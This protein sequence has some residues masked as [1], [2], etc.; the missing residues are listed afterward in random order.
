MNLM[1][2]SRFLF[3]P[4]GGVGHIGMN[5]SLYHYDGKWI[6]VDLG[7]GF[8]NDLMPGVDITV[9]DVSFIAERKN[10]LL[11]IVLTHAH[12]DHIGAI[13]YLWNELGCPLFATNFTANF[14]KAK[15]SEFGLLDKVTINYVNTGDVL[16]IG[17]FKIEFVGMTHSIPEAQSLVIKTVAG[18]VVHTGDWKI[19]SD[20]VIGDVSNLARLKAVGDEGVDCLVCDSTNVFSLGYSGTEASV[21][22]GLLEV[23]KGA[24]TGMVAVALFASNI[25][26]IQT[27]CDVAKECGRRICLLGRSLW[28]IVEVAKNSGYLLDVEE[29]VD[30]HETKLIDREK[31]LLICTGC[32]G[33]PDAAAHKLANLTHPSVELKNGDTVVFSS[34]IIPGNECRIYQMLNLFAQR[35]IHVITSTEKHVHV[36]GHPAR[37][38][39]REMYALI[40]PR[41]ALPVH[42][43]YLHMF[44]H[45]NLALDFGAKKVVISAPGDVIDVIAAE[46]IDKVV[47]G[48]FGV[49]GNFLHHPEGEVMVMR[50]KMRDS[51][52]VVVTVLTNRS[53]TQILR[54]PIIFAPGVFDNQSDDGL[55]KELK[56]GVVVAVGA[57]NGKKLHSQIRGAVRSILKRETGSRPV[58]EVQVERL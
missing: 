36:S 34:K 9:A 18:T 14:V 5:V 39:L 19:D 17:P 25:A 52:I 55:V 43:E 48:Y 50:R 29:F 45:Q 41:I 26:R 22:D 8:A 54:G 56:K 13:Q 23:V 21:R 47:S 44:E 53:G 10:D 6:M 46:K 12:E 35:G 32:Q 31:F 51:G 15:I 58:I 30:V 4:L 42:G 33:E 11:G 7:A 57:A 27:I 24:G 16:D 38:E 40:R 2:N 1:D 28:R 37:D 49:D 3:V 20:P